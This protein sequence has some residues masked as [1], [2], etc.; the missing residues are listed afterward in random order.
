MTRFAF[1]AIPVAVAS[2]SPLR[3]WLARWWRAIRMVTTANQ[4]SYKR[5][6]FYS[7]D[8]CVTEHGGSWGVSYGSVGNRP[9]LRY[10]QQ[11]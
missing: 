3:R 8:A 6:E 2:E 4:P 9:L 5:G 11:D 1:A 7:Y 10:P